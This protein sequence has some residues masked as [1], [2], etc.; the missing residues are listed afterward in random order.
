[1]PP[2][3]IFTKDDRFILAKPKAFEQKKEVCN[4]V[5]DSMQNIFRFE[6]TEKMSKELRNKIEETKDSLIEALRYSISSTNIHYGTTFNAFNNYLTFFF[7]TPF[8][9][10]K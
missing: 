2:E 6:K 3:S 5:K 9:L 4:L 10:H 1:L 8:F 7:S